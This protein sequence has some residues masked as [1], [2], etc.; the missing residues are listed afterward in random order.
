MKT[1]AFQTTG[2]IEICGLNPLL[3]PVPCDQGCIGPLQAKGYF[4]YIYIS[5][6]IPNS[7]AERSVSVLLVGHD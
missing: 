4:I 6:A 1:P 7:L 2:M 5:F 3:N